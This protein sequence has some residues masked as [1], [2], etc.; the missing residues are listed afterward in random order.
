MDEQK[1]VDEYTEGESAFSLREK[2]ISNQAFIEMRAELINKFENTTYDQAND[3]TEIWR[4]M[5]VIA[6]F[7]GIL[8]EIIQTG[9]IAEE[10]LKGFSKFKSILK[11]K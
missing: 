4:K 1:I 6:W 8:T 3:R 5:Q 11:G 2:L 10:E 9:K 7:D